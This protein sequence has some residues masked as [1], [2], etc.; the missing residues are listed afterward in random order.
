VDVSPVARVADAVWQYRLDREPYLRVRGGLPVDRLPS[1]S[2]A[3]V[4]ERSDFAARMLRELAVADRGPDDDP[5]TEGFLRF[6]LDGWLRAP[7]VH[8][9]GFSCTPYS[10]FFLSFGV[11][12][13]FGGY[14]FA[15]A[16]DVDRYL[17][18][19]ADYRA[20]VTEL[21]V[22]LLGQRARGV[23]LPQP[24]VPGVVETLRRYREAAPALLAVAEDRSADLPAADAARLRD[25]VDRLVR[26]EVVPA[27]DAL[28]AVLDEDYRTAAPDRVGFAQYP[29]G[30]QFYRE[31]VRLHTASDQ[32]PERIHEIGLEQVAALADEMA[33]LRAEL[34]VT[35]PER[36]FHVALATDPRFVATTPEQVEQRYLQHMAALEPLL[37]AWFSRLPRAPYGV[38]RLPEH[39]A[40]AMTY[41]YYAPPTSNQP[42]GRYV[43][44]GS[45][46]EQR[47]MLTAATLIFHELAPGHHFHFARQAE[48]DALPAIRREA[49][50]IG[51]FNEGWAEYAAGLGWEM[52]LYEDPYDRYGRLVHERFTAQRL[53]VDTGLNVLGWS[54][55]Q[56][57]EYMSANTTES[58]VQVATETLRYATDLPA[59]ALAYRSGF[60]ELQRLRAQ[61]EQR[62]G[63]RFDVRDYHEAVLG[64]G[65]LPF[66]VLQDH[67][68]RWA[69]S[70]EQT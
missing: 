60:L 14:R 11:R 45:Q 68:Q 58:P 64:Q 3:E 2:L 55:E 33:K 1:G 46:L 44:N 29:G 35:L 37:S 67:L 7:D 25:G 13:V 70:Q 41:G 66:P 26:D 62:L 5:V 39:M 17:S 61:A 9:L 56:A 23:L 10:S 49:M 40:T 16:G 48:N 43:Y 15:G 32:E 4:E 19:P 36:E 69:D 12:D 30:E 22:K 8:W 31:H 21:R 18:L 63:D 38:E 59:Q 54:L 27:Y 53:V 28:L 50:D 57:R 52:G 47:S 24:A 6:L 65:A 42:T 20:F 51:A 34:G